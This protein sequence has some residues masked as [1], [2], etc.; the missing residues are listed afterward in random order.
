MPEFPYVYGTDP[1][2]P[3]GPGGTRLR[4][5]RRR[6]RDETR[7]G[8]RGPEQDGGG[9]ED[10]WRELLEQ[11]VAE[12]NRSFE[13]ARVPFVCTLD[14]DPAGFSLHVRRTDAAAGGT[15]EV[16]ELLEPA[17]LPRWLARL[18]IRLGLLVD[19]TV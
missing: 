11:A 14:E 18:R 15:E 17:E 13:S 6:P 9:R 8:D 12:L 5:L 2:L 1:A 7:D 19:R 4:V 16:E 3:V 10:A